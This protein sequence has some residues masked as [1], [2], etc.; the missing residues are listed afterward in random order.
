[1]AAPSDVGRADRPPL[2]AASLDGGS[3]TVVADPPMDR[4]GLAEVIDR[5]TLE[6]GAA[7][8]GSGAPPTSAAR[9]WRERD[10]SPTAQRWLTLLGNL[11]GAGGA[12]YFAYAT[13]Q[14]YLH[15]HRL[16]GA[17][18][19][20]EQMVV[21]VAFLVRRPARV[22]TRRLGD[23]LLAFG[24]TFAGVLFRPEGA[25]PAW[26]VD[27]G[28]ALQVTGLVLCVASLL[29]LGRSFGFAA[30][31]RGLVVRGPYAVVRHPVYAS[32][33]LLQSG[34]VLQSMSLRNVVVLLIL[35]SCNVGR[36]RAEERVLATNAQYSAYRARVRWRLLPGL[37]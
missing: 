36:V 2:T 18:F 1:M 12:A 28:L 26:G 7:T 35:W 21:V 29:A 10:L 8:G 27:L 32:Y 37:W 5:Q 6:A 23:W 19:F 11:V 14:F 20:V 33:V 30:A 15:T 3:I 16:L 31:D 13:L 4:S 25:H 9:S 22:V 24:G 34:Y 17:A